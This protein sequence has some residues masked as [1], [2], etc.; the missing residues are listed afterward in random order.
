MK[1]RKN[2]LA[3]IYMPVEYLKAKYP[4]AA[5][6]KRILKKWNNRFGN[7]LEIYDRNPFL[8]LLSKEAPS[9]GVY[10][11]VPVDLNDSE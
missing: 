6:R 2:I 3:Q 10:Y 5:K 4:K 8:E 7:D 1:F 9:T 11:P